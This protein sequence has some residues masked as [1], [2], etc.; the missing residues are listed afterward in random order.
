MSG[1][2]ASYLCCA[3]GAEWDASGAGGHHGSCAT[4]GRASSELD[5]AVGP[6][7]QESQVPPEPVLQEQVEKL[8]PSAG[9]KSGGSNARTKPL[10][11][12]A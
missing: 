8:E 10:S 11:N 6:Q 2:T 12:Q 5:I 1:L 9:R 7:M 4:A 3:I